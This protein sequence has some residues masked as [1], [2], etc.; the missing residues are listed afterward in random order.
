[1]ERHNFLEKH[2]CVNFFNATLCVNVS[3]SGEIGCQHKCWK[4][5]HH[6]YRSGNVCFSL[7]SFV[8]INTLK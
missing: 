3:L 4:Y 2:N 8:Y 6:I 5:V 1:M 7:A